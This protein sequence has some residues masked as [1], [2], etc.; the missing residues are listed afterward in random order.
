MECTFCKKVFD[1]KNVLQHHKRTAKYCLEIQGTTITNFECKYCKKYLSTNERLVTHLNVCKLK[2][3]YESD[4]KF[5]ELKEQYDTK[6]SLQEDHYKKEIK[7]IQDKLQEK[8][9]YI[10]KLESKLDKFENTVTHMASFT[11]TVEKKTKDESNYN[12]PIPLS[13]QMSSIIEETKEDIEYLNITLNNIVITS[14]P[15]DHYVN[16]TQLCKAGG[17]KFSHWFS[18]D[19]TKEL[20]NELSSDNGIPVSGLSDK[21]VHGV[22]IHPDLSIQLAQWISTKFAIQI[23]KWVRT[24]FNKDSIEIDINMLHEKDKE[25][26]IKDNRIKQL[27]SVCLSKQRR[28]DYPERNVI[29]ML[30]TE[31]HLKRRTYIIG[32]AKNLTNRLS[33]YNKTCDHT[34]VHYRECNNED[35]MATAETM[36]LNKLRDHREQANRDRFILPDDKAISFFTQTIDECI[37]FI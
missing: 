22:W 3:S 33:T 19:T 6:M 36:I 34:V 14:R 12:S 30:T 20:I 7:V 9:E 29:Y 23:S 17:K 15:L 11:C 37:R 21:S 26:R 10:A 28:I 25:I 2:T 8:N 24:L 18:L 1:T 5:D 13:E 16:A 31:D 27:E 35:D 4:K 32:K